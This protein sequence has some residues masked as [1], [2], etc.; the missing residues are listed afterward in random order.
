VVQLL[1]SY[2]LIEERE[3]AEIVVENLEP[4]VIERLE[5]RARQRGRTLQAELKQILEEASQNECSI[6]DEV[7]T[8]RQKAFLMSKQIASHSG[9]EITEVKPGESE[10]VSKAIAVLNTLKQTISPGEMSIRE[11]REEGRRF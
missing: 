6:A 5:A 11:M 4:L 7:E 9:L 2:I 3:M 10:N 1:L 8:L